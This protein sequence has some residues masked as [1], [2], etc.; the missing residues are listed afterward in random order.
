MSA[1]QIATYKNNSTLIIPPF[2]NTNSEDISL[3]P[4]WN[5]ILV[6][7]TSDPQVGSINQ[8][9]IL[10]I[11]FFSVAPPPEYSYI[12]I[13][14]YRFFAKN[15]AN[16]TKKDWL[17]PQGAAPGD[18]TAAFRSLYYLL[19][20]HPKIASDY[21]VGVNSTFVNIT[22]T[23]KNPGATFNITF[24]Q[25]GF[26]LPFVLNNVTSNYS[27]QNLDEFRFLLE[28]YK[29]FADTRN[30]LNP[31]GTIAAV[32]DSITANIEKSFDYRN[33]DTLFDISTYFTQ[34]LQAYAP[35][36]RQNFFDRNAYECTDMLQIY[37]LR[38]GDIYETV[39]NNIIVDFEDYV[40]TTAST[41]YAN[42]QFAVLNAALDKNLTQS[43]YN[44][45]CNN[46][47]LRNAQNTFLTNWDNQDSYKIDSIYGTGE[48]YDISKLIHINQHEFLYF[49]YFITDAQRTDTL[50]F[51]HFVV[52]EDGNT[53][54]YN[55]T[56][57]FY[58]NN[59]VTA[60]IP[61]GF[62]GG[63]YYVEVGIRAIEDFTSL[64]LEQIE[65]AANSKIKYIRI[66]AQRRARGVATRISNYAYYQLDN[67]NRFLENPTQIYY[68]NAWGGF[69]SLFAY[70][71]DVK[72]NN[73]IVTAQNSGLEQIFDRFD[74]ETMYTQKKYNSKN[75][76]ITLT[77]YIPYNEKW[78]FKTIKECV[79]STEFY[80]Y[81]ESI[82]EQYYQNQLKPEFF[83]A[84]CT[85]STVDI[86]DRIDMQAVQLTFDVNVNNNINS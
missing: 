56:Y 19:K 23:A 11:S 7:L 80:I 47:I 75:N 17:L 36:H 52:F 70:Y 20:Y 39:N 85:T 26:A 82:F 60:T 68:K 8:T 33:P 2:I 46:M 16:L 18:W 61:G 50:E 3:M 22:L 66:N 57:D 79:S 24:N 63:A 13:N 15:P 44:T 65:T 1:T 69:D 37:Y 67:V 12:E 38:F 84:I 5:Q 62:Y 51:Q 6:G 32:T 77:C 58:I 4:A 76:K 21:Y 29:P 81:N 10:N 42:R 71:T 28:V 43:E 55:I 78:N 64:T 30:F 34:Y 35:S 86:I 31:V 27:A 59:L 83:N 14:G 25:V 73:E 54:T 40:A 45:A 48:R 9:A 41:N 53:Q 49:L 72:Y 74:R